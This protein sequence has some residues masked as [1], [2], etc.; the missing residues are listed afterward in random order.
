MF[1]FLP[2]FLG[3][4]SVF[5][6]LSLLNYE[7][8]WDLPLPI[9][10]SLVVVLVKL[11]LHGRARKIS[12]ENRF[13]KCAAFYCSV[14]RRASQALA[15]TT[16]VPMNSLFSCLLSAVFAGPPHTACLHHFLLYKLKFLYH[17]Y[18]IPWKFASRMFDDLESGVWDSRNSYCSRKVF[19]G[20]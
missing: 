7:M 14:Y 6:A 13:C 12:H 3:E 15:Y 17:R 9:S 1:S 8:I 18:C 20:I 10:A 16:Q 19:S 4:S 11:L 2:G 5:Y